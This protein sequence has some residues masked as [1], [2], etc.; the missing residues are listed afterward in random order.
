MPIKGNWALVYREDG[1]NFSVNGNTPR[2]VAESII[3]HRMAN[4]KPANVERV[5]D[6]CLRE[7]YKR[8]PDRFRGWRPPPNK[9]KE[10]ASL[11]PEVLEP[12]FKAVANNSADQL[13]VRKRKLLEGFEAQ[14]LECPECTK[15]LREYMASETTK[16]LGDWAYGLYTRLMTHW[17]YTAK[18]KPLLAKEWNWR[19]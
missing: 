18:P 1:L 19:N 13:T 12:M 10:Q 6:Y 5:K 3:Q 17:G 2:H 7:W 14:S 16:N 11:G 15:I 4:K 8:D 9:P